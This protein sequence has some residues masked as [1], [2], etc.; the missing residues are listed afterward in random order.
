MEEL[1]VRKGLLQESLG[2]GRAKCL[3]C[4]RMCE[5]PEGGLGFCKTRQNIS[6]EIYTLIYGDISSMSANPIE[7]KPLFHVFPGTKALTVGSWGC[8]FRLSLVPELGD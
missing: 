2:G 6:G 7:K 3:T 5:I 8:N 1:C 4:M